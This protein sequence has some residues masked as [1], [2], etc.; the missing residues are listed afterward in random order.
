VIVSLAPLVPT[1]NVVEKITKRDTPSAFRPWQT[2]IAGYQNRP[3]GLFCLHHA[4]AVVERPPTTGSS[5]IT[6]TPSHYADV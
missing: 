6:T 4:R 1:S 5:M 3:M 2:A